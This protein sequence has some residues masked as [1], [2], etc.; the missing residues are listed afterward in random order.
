MLRKQRAIV[1]IKPHKD[2]WVVTKVEFNMLSE[3]ASV[4]V[5]SRV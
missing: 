1:K 4:N 2:A 3:L 5:L